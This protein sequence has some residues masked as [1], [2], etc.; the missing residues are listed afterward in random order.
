MSATEHP[1]RL[2]AAQGVVNDQQG[3]PSH[4]ASLKLAQREGLKGGGGDEP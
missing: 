3:Q 1:L 4:P 2:L